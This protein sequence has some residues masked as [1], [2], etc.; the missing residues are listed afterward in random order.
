[1]RYTI[2]FD[3]NSS[4]AMYYSQVTNSLCPRESPRGECSS[5]KTNIYGTTKRGSLETA[6]LV[7]VRSALS[8]RAQTK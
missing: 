1:M 5:R 3:L 6:G 2:L 8:K 7:V 4:L